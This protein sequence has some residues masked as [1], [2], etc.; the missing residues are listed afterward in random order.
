M[1]LNLTEE[2][3]PQTIKEKSIWIGRILD[4]NYK[5]YGFE[6]E[7]HKL[8]HLSKIQRVILLSFLKRYE[9]LFGG[10]IGEWTVP[11]VLIPIKEEAKPYHAQAFPIP[12]I[13]IEAIRNIWI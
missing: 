7:V 5:N 10:N 11:A 9:D 4:A 1:D 8:I 2:E 12:L 6:Q 13:H 3:Y